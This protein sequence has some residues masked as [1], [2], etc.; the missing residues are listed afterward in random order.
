MRQYIFT[1]FDASSYG[2]WFAAEKKLVTNFYD[3]RLLQVHPIDI[4]S[5]PKS[6]YPLAQWSSS[7]YMRL[8]II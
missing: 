6:L 7:R 1:T 4:D 5:R 2:L 3:R 8:R